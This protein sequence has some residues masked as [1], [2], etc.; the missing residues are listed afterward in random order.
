MTLSELLA[1]YDIT[2][3]D[4]STSLEHRLSIQPLPTSAELTAGEEAFWNRHAGMALSDP[5]ASPLARATDETVSVLGAASRSLTIEQAADLLGV[6]RSRVSHRLRDGRLYAFQLGTQRRLPRWQLTTDDTPLPGLDAVLAA[7]PADLHPAA[8]EGFF[9]T[10]DPDLD[11]E[12]PARWLASGGD[13]HRVVD[14][15]AGIDQW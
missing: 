2:E 12:T 4:L 11:G 10:P 13:P 7:L 15:A 5:E 1:Q 8:V 9:T 6:H 14:E 3:D